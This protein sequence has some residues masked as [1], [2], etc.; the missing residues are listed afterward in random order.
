MRFL[1]S[2]VAYPV[3]QKEIKEL[4]SSRIHFQQ[5]WASWK[6]TIEVKDASWRHEGEELV[7]GG[8]GEHETVKALTKEPDST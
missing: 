6:A 7:G 1:G 3:G 8:G 5:E 4:V 2:P